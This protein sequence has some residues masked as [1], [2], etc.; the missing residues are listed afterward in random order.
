MEEVVEVIGRLTR[1]REIKEL[2]TVWKLLGGEREGHRWRN[3]FFFFFGRAAF[4]ILSNI[5]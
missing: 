5:D 3:V 4:V 1:D 2:G